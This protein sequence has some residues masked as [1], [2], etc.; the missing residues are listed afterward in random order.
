MNRIPVVSSNV[1]SVR[2]DPKTQTLEVEFHNG[3]VYQYF[4]V[5]QSV[6]DAFM[7]AESKGGFLNSSIKG[8]YRYAKL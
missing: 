6:Y 4:D 7:S 3:T 2:Y 8:V 1:A 5:S